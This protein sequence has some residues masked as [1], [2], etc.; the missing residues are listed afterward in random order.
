MQ[1]RVQAG[2]VSLPDGG[3][4]LSAALAQRR[5][6]LRRKRDALEG[7]VLTFRDAGSN[8]TQVSGW[9]LGGWV[10]CVSASSGS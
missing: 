4:K 1:A 2:T 6:V 7:R 10:A 3:I 9:V 5:E 8:A